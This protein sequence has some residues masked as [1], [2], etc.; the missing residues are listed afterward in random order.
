LDVPIPLAAVLRPIV[1]FCARR[2]SSS[3]RT[4]DRVHNSTACWYPSDRSLCETAT[5]PGHRQHQA[6]TPDR[7]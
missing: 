5:P 1:S 2:S 3:L 7:A 6:R 4:L